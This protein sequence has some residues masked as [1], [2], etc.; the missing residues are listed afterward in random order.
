MAVLLPSI[1]KVAGKMIL[2]MVSKSPKGLKLITGA[3]KK[4]AANTKLGKKVVKA[5]DLGKKVKKVTSQ[6]KIS[7]EML[8][9]KDAKDVSKFLKT[10]K[11]KDAWEK[12]YETKFGEA[13]ISENENVIGQELEKKLFKN[14]TDL[15]KEIE[16][17]KK[18]T[19]EKSK[20]LK[21]ADEEVS[22]EYKL[23]EDEIKE[24]D[25]D[26]LESDAA[27]EYQVPDDASNELKSAK[28]NNITK[29]IISKLNAI[30]KIVTVNNTLLS[31]SNTRDSAII[32]SIDNLSSNTILT[33]D[34]AEAAL[35]S[36]SNLPTIIG[37]SAT[38]L[39][40][41]ISEQV[42][43][44]PSIISENQA[45]LIPEIISEQVSLIPEVM[46]NQA[47]LIP[48]TDASDEITEKL[49]GISDQLE[50]QSEKTKDLTDAMSSQIAST[51][52]DAKNKA[53]AV[54]DAVLDI[55]AEGAKIVSF[56]TS[57]I[58]LIFSGELPKLVVAIV[59]GVAKKIGNLLRPEERVY[60]DPSYAQAIIDNPLSTQQ[61]RLE[62]EK[63]LRDIEHN[64]ARVA[65]NDYSKSLREMDPEDITD[66]MIQE[67]YRLSDEV[68]VAKARVDDLK[69]QIKSGA[70]DA[71]T[72]SY[73]D[74]DSRAAVIETINLAEQAELD[75]IASALASGNY[76]ELTGHQVYIEG[77]EHYFDNIHA[78]KELLKI[79]KTKKVKDLTPSDFDM[80]SKYVNQAT[81][82]D[83]YRRVWKL[84]TNP[85][86][87]AILE[88][89]W[90]KDP[91]FHNNKKVEQAKI[92][93]TKAST[94][95]IERSNELMREREYEAASSSTKA[96]EEIKDLISEGTKTVLNN[97]TVSVSNVNTDKDNS[98][99][100]YE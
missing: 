20:D 22:E 73:S 54:E 92:E 51:I 39:P 14:T 70:V 65:W 93:A 41:I 31:T 47:S 11:E 25:E 58:K 74:N 37:S 33:A 38:N 7:S 72:F 56:L 62:A 30:G 16:L 19:E 82:E 18:I 95:V 85:E 87:R 66:E 77:K 15:N 97:T 76:D 84:T 68:N 55:T 88:E 83:Y 48:S 27:E 5:I 9:A 59:A 42:R 35:S 86:T 80:L 98:I 100:N 10:L 12:K 90:I 29:S 43:E 6:N 60:E 94:S 57:M 69:K 21:E 26:I 32:S 36:T 89:H 67:D 1:I 17:A 8:K 81:R 28:I 78:R 4:L 71:D 13:K 24:S 50:V 75:N 2:R 52:E 61:E 34:V 46:S 63:E 99:S 91:L 53:G 40:A 79:F 44:L 3:G 64:N 23:Q 96:T 49:S 45:S